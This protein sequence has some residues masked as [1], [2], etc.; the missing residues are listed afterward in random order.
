MF[1]RDLEQ[2]GPQAPRHAPPSL[3]EANA[4]CRRLALTHYENFPVVTRL[5]PSR[6][7]QHFSNIYAW[8]RWAD[9]LADETAGPERAL[10]L[11]EWWKDELERCRAGAAAHPVTV[12]LT[13]T[14]VEFGIPR[15]PFLDL[16]SA[17]Q[18]DQR[19]TAYETFEDLCDYCRRSANPVGRLVLYLCRQARPENFHWSD[20]ICTGLQLANFW[21]D[22]ARDLAI[23]RVYL[24]REDCRRFGVSFS[25][26]TGQQGGARFAA[27][28]RFQVD[29]ARGYLWPWGTA[30]ARELW[31][32]EWR[33]HVTIEMFARGGA[34][35]LDRIEKI[36]Y[37]VLEKRPSLSRLDLLRVATACI[38]SVVLSRL[39]R[40]TVE[41]GQPWF[42]ASQR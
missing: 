41:F 7:R 5:L 34:R 37:R 30:R 25:D 1:E 39:G 24:P 38:A 42:R 12:A 29:R 22:V 18:Q 26:L 8:C 11:L 2:W 13:Q 33:V 9:D 40:A 10:A 31:A 28:M 36:N 3:D 16:L 6:L 23:G 14:I 21:Q 20:S 35:V 19:V 27:L 17:F 4:Y 15:E 32:F